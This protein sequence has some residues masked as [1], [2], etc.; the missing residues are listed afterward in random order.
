MPR[1]EG[2]PR[3]G[4]RCPSGGRPCREYRSLPDL[5]AIE[6]RSRTRHDR[7]DRTGPQRTGPAR[8]AGRHPRTGRW[9]PNDR[10]ATNRGATRP[11]AFDPQQRCRLAA[12]PSGSVVGRNPP[13]GVGAQWRPAAATAGS[14]DSRRRTSRSARDAADEEPGTDAGHLPAPPP[15][16][17]FGDRSGEPHRLPLRAP[18]RRAALAAPRSEPAPLPPRAP[19]SRPLRAGR[20]PAGARRDPT[21][22]RLTA[23]PTQEGP[24]RDNCTSRRRRPSSAAGPTPEA[25]LSSSGA[26]SGRSQRSTGGAPVGQDG[27]QAPY[28]RRPCAPSSA[29]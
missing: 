20:G 5:G 13:A 6:H 10:R 21:A 28:H 23:G 3:R 15:P 27:P 16:W 1:V 18:G 14:A 7:A 11:G 4:S 9:M 25:A 17:A 22:A 29:S 19:S 8:S 26:A 24:A 12:R 2:N